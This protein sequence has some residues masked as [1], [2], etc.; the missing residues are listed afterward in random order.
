MDKVEKKLEN[1][2]N[3]EEKILKAK[4]NGLLMLLVYLILLAGAILTI[5]VNGNIIDSGNYTSLNIVFL[6]IGIVF[7]ALGW[8]M[9]LGLKLLKPQE[10]LVLTLFG[11]YIGGC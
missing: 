9:L 5:A 8:I 4:K 1:S 10:S 11:K 6:V 3:V 2:D 7:A